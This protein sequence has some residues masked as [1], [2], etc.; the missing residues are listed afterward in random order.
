MLTGKKTKELTKIS[1][2][3]RNCSID[4]ENVVNLRY[5]NC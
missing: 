4:S 3:V 1:R 5:A 2:D